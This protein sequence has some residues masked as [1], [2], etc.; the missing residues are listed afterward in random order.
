MSLIKGIGIGFSDITG[1]YK[2]LSDTERLN[3]IALDL[4][5]Y[6]NV[7][8]IDDVIYTGTPH[9]PTP[10]VTAVVGGETITLVKDR[11]YTLSYKNN[12]NAGQ[13]TVTITG[14]SPFTGTIEK[15]WNINP[16]DITVVVQNQTYVYNHLEQGSG[17][18]VSVVDSSTPTVEYRITSSGDYTLTSVPTRMDVGTTTVYY[19]VT[20]PNH[21]DNVG[22]YTLTITSLV[23]VLSWGETTWTYDGQGHSTTCV[24]SNLIPGDTCDVILGNNS[25]TNI[26]SETVTAIALSNS[27]YTL[28]GATN[29]SVIITIVAGMFVKIS[30]IWTPVK[31]VYRKE[32]GSWVY[33][34]NPGLVF[35]TSQMYIK[36][37]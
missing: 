22:S 29:T 20:A 19:K 16:A 15:N 3:V 21:N 28:E 11:D 1:T 25:I 33:Y 35:S 27:N 31:K 18:V 9:T 12:T 34:E 30:G 7:L 23:A 10:I 4:A 24:V 26:G 5:E 17:V 14:L 13:A 2:V 32:N 6:G 8:S 37:N 36:K